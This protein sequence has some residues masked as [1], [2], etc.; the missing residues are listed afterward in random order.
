M[1]QKVGDRLKH[2]PIKLRFTTTQPNGQP[3]QVL[4]R[5]LNQA[6]SE[7]IQPS[8]MAQQTPTILYELLDVSISE[9]ETKRSLKVIWTGL[10]NKEE[11]THSFLLPRTYTVN[12]LADHITKQVSLTATGSHTIRI[13]VISKDGKRQ[14]EFGGS[15]MVGNIPDGT[16]L[17][18]EAS[19]ILQ[20]GDTSLTCSI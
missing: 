3:K 1:S 6:V 15:E 2:D 10:A 16:E 11:G 17:Y 7:I 5:S 13:F 9:L 14:E 4:K 20:N 12:D 19:L 18:A 8:Y